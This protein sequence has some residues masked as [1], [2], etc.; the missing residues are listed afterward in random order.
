M[1]K[2]L[3]TKILVFLVLHWVNWRMQGNNCD[4]Y[5]VGQGGEDTEDPALY[6]RRHHRYT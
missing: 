1:L 2:P 4:Y 6:F 3:T 5:Y